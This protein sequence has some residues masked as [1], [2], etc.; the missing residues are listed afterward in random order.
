MGV[1]PLCGA[2]QLVVLQHAQPAGLQGLPMAQAVVG[3]ADQGMRVVSCPVAQGQI[4]G[5][6][7]P[8]RARQLR[9][10]GQIGGLIEQGAGLGRRIGAGPHI[11][12]EGERQ[13]WAAAQSMELLVP[14]GRG[15][16]DQQRPTRPL[17]PGQGAGQPSRY[18]RQDQVIGLARPGFPVAAPTLGRRCAS[19][20]PH[21]AAA[22]K[23]L[24]GLLD[25]RGRAGV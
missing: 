4:V 21:I 2:H 5:E 10:P 23:A 16:H 22:A 24:S 3:D 20:Q 18:P 17:A 7:R 15:H 12:V 19:L 8:A 6:R 14:P 25:R 9:R 13:V 11:G 1:K